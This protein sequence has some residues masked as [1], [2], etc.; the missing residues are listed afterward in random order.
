MPVTRREFLTLSGLA[1]ASALLTACV[2]GRALP[3]APPP[4]AGP[5]PAGPDATWPALS[6]LTFGP[7]LDERAHAAAIGQDAWIEE[8]L[9]PESLADAEAEW[10]VRHFDTPGMDTS[11][12]FDVR[13]ETVRRELQQVTL[14]RAVYSRRQLYEIIVDF[15]SDHFSISTHKG[16][17]AWLKTIDD[18]AVIRPQALG[19]FRDLLWASMHSPAMLVFLDNQENYKDGSNENYARELLE[20]HTLGVG[21]GYTQQDVQEVARCLTGWT[22][23][24]GLFRG[25]FQ[26][27]A[28]RHD[29]GAKRVLGQAIP[30]G[31]GAQDGE[32]VHALVLAHPA[33]PHFIARKLVQRLV[34]D[35]PP[36]ALVAA[37]A[38]TFTRTQGDIKAVLRTILHGAAFATAPPKIKRPLHYVAGALR[39]L[40]AETDAAP[41]LLTA[42]AAMGQP[43][44]QW[45]RPDGFPDTAAAW[46]AN[47]FP[48][49][50]FA[51]ALATGALPGVTIDLR[52]LLRV[53]GPAGAATMAAVLDHFSTRLLGRPLPRPA[54]EALLPH[55]GQDT[56]DTGLQAAVAVLLAGPAY[57]WR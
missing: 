8:Q 40:A 48:R 29:A 55:L 43:L 36:A 23:D 20:L 15:W 47:L 41:A 16:T 24:R 4:P 45:P 51:L 50:Q 33:L 28:G 2:P 49:W 9:A 21:A 27:D 25:Q 26:F 1:A 46:Q 34:A 54:V 6:R 39:Q 56:D 42:L 11:I 30:A 18:R 57:Q 10:R 13:E 37:A 35:D 31:G 5:W 32:R 44:F 7:R 52:A 53:A 19:S 17:C 38:A 14:L 12:L 3:G 22:V